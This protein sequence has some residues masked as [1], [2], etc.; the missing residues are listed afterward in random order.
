MTSSQAAAAAAGAV[1][2]ARLAPDARPIVA[3][4]GNLF[5]L[6]GHARRRGDVLAFVR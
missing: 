1:P 3:L 5:P 6:G 4:P 2:A